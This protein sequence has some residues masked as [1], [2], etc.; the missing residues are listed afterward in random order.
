MSPSQATYGDALVAAHRALVEDLQK[1]DQAP[2]DETVSPA[3]LLASLERLRGRLVEHFRFEEQNGYLDWVVER[4]PNLDRP[5][6]HLAEEHRLLLSSLDELLGETR[7]AAAAAAALKRKAT[8][9]S[10]R[11]R[12]HERD[13][14]LLVE[15]AFN[16]DLGAED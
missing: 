14:N 9:W 3:K 6:Q 2:A 10:R 4:Q 5:V 12:R 8:E 15:D 11:V 7:A 16:L 1:L 13:E